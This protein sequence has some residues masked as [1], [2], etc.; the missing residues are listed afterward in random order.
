MSWHHKG[1]D[2]ASSQAFFITKG[3]T[4]CVCVF[5]TAVPITKLFAWWANPPNLDKCLVSK[6][7]MS[8]MKTLKPPDLDK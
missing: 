1:H 5:I 6:K 3:D 7:G 4:Q 8:N 2:S